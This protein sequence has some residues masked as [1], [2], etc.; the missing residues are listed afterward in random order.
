MGGEFSL[1]T[2]KPSVVLRVCKLFRHFQGAQKGPGV[3]RVGAA[4]IDER[5]SRCPAVAG[6]IEVR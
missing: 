5:R 6:E 4:A 3:P 2:K 1:F